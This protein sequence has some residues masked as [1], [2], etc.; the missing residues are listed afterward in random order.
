[1]VRICLALP[2]F[3]NDRKEAI[4]K[5]VIN[6]AEQ[7]AQDD[8]ITVSTL[9]PTPFKTQYPIKQTHFAIE[10]DYAHLSAASQET[11]RI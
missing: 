2:R 10:Q 7:F 3:R 8:D 1:M 5:N 9:T 6:L 4:S 11:Q